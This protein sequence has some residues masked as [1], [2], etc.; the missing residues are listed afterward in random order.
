MEIER[1]REQ[2]RIRAQQQQQQQQRLLEQ[3]R[4]RADQR[5][6]RDAQELLELQAQFQATSLESFGRRDTLPARTLE[7]P[8]TTSAASS[9][10]QSQ[11]HSA[12]Q[13]ALAVMSPSSKPW[14]EVV[15]P[16]YPPPPYEKYGTVTYHTSGPATSAGRVDVA[17]NRS[18]EN[19][20]HSR[21][22]GSSFSGRRQLSS[23]SNS[24]ATLPH[25]LATRSSS[26]PYLNPFP[27][28]SNT[29]SRSSGSPSSSASPL[30][31]SASSGHPSSR[32]PHAR[33]R[34]HSQNQPRFAHKPP[35]ISSEASSPIQSSSQPRTSVRRHPS[36]G[37]RRSARSSN[38]VLSAANTAPV[39]SSAEPEDD[40]FL[41]VDMIGRRRA[42]SSSTNA[43]TCADS[44]SNGKLGL[45]VAEYI[46]E[47]HRDPALQ[48]YNWADVG[49]VE[50]L[51][52]RRGKCAT[53]W[54]TMERCLREYDSVFEAFY[55]CVSFFLLL[56]SSWMS[57]EMM[58]FP[59]RS[60]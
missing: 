7:Y 32:S 46:L 4:T 35:L 47:V 12:P 48:T 23:T 16:E 21:N 34:S 19:L 25:M 18:Q 28:T 20:G 52:T 5:L 49:I 45:L 30:N 37:R 50:K 22:R 55:Q 13:T 54:A 43:N 36:H 6:R 15:L 11:T 41:R 56:L 51:L 24:S 42:L 59:E 57:P 2:E 60:C 58:F 53:G 9:Q 17:H 40:D 14:E 8:C 3:A 29:P 26:S 10:S 27:L 39:P 44:H 1:A 31:L 38:Q 33:S